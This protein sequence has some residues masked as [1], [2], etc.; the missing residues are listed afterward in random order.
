[1]RWLAHVFAYVHSWFWYAYNITSMF[2]FT[3]CSA[4]QGYHEYKEIWDS[5]I[6]GEE[7]GCRREVGNPHDTN[8]VAVIKQIDE[9]NRIVGHV[10]RRISAPCNAFICRGGIIKC[11]V[12]GSRKYNVDLPQGGLEV[13]CKLQF[14]ILAEEFCRKTEISVCAALSKTNTF[15]LVKPTSMIDVPMVGAMMLVAADTVAVLSTVSLVDKPDEKAMIE[16]DT[17]TTSQNQCESRPLSLPAKETCSVTINNQRTVKDDS[18]VV[19]EIACSPPKKRLKKF[20]EEAIIMGERLTDNEINLAQR[21]L[22]AQFPNFNGLHSTLLQSKPCAAVEQND[23]K[24]QIVFCNDR[25]HWILATTVGCEI[26]GEVK[27][28]DSIFSSLDKD[29]LCTVMKLFSSGNN[30]P[31]VRLSPSQ[32]QKGTNDCGVLLFLLLWQLLSD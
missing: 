27:V 29:S 5:L 26:V 32:K 24:I 11:I 7:L 6:I 2:E 1:M 25:N 13:P 4:I 22:K 15:S 31:R 18:I 10:S 19:D 20:N 14:S 9:H 16:M 3:I 28:Y 8:A 21:I 12:I 23:N 17:V 30:K